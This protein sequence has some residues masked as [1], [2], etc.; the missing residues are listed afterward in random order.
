ML[1]VERCQDFHVRAACKLEAAAH[2]IARGELALASRRAVGEESARHN[3][4]T[5]LMYW[6]SSMC[7]IKH[8]VAMFIR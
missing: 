3:E 6:K 5:E 4:R 1:V 8:L 2:V 7:L